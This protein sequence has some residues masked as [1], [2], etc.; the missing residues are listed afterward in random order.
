MTHNN[1]LKFG[2]RS[3]FDD[4][5]NSQDR[6]QVYF[7]KCT[8]K[9]MDWK[10]ECIRATQLI[11]DLSSG[12]STVMMSGGI[13][14]EVVALSFLEA[15]APFKAA[16]L[17]LKNDLNQHDIIWAIKFC[18][19]NNVPYY[20]IELDIHQFYSSEEII[21]LAKLM[22]ISAAMNLVQ[23]KIA[24][25]ILKRDEFPVS[26]NGD[27]LFRKYNKN[28]YFY[29]AEHFMRLSLITQKHG[30]KGAIWF[31]QYTPELICSYLCDDIMQ[32]F[33][34][35]HFIQ[36]KSENYPIRHFGYYPKNDLIDS[37]YY[38]DIKMK[39]IQKYFKVIRRPKYKGFENF[40]TLEKTTSLNLD[41][42]LIA[43]TEHLFFHPNTILKQISY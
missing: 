4:R 43:P 17:K 41:Q 1:H 18:E 5:L 20:F 16:I 37:N 2:Y 29:F 13:D 11:N 9:P 23:C 42:Y 6:F 32:S 40:E 12:R 35:E 22:G 8:Q 39:M 31:F 26:G 21:K 24:L 10:N 27:L 33:F 15:K 14:S 28:W 34:R 38:R 30:K 3:S 36:D 19:N 25:E 7:S